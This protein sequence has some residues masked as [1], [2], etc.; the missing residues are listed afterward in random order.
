MRQPLFNV[1]VEAA[2]NNAGNASSAHDNRYRVNTTYFGDIARM[3][4]A[5][6]S[7]II[8]TYHYWFLRS[9]SLEH[10]QT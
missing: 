4:A 7:N 3:R 1:T 8:R 6:R 10:P 9:T 5:P 2:G